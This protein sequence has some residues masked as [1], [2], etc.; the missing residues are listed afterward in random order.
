MPDKKDQGAPGQDMSSIIAQ[1]TALLEHQTNTTPAASFRLELAVPTYEGHTDKKSVAD[2]LQEMQDYRDA[3]AITDDV[4]QRVLPVALTGSAARWRRRQSFQSWTHFEQLLRAEFLPPGYVVRMKDELRARSQAEKE[5]L[6]EYISSFQEL[7]ERADPSAPEMERVTR[8]IRQS[9][10]RFQAYLR[11]RTFS[12]LDD[13]AKAAMLAELTYQ[14]PSP[15]QAS[16]EPSCAWHCSQIASP[17]NMVPPPRAL[18]PFIH[19]TFATQR[20]PPSQAQKI[21]AGAFQ[22]A[23]SAEDEA[24]TRA[25]ARAPRA[26]YSRETTR[27]GG[28]EQ[29]PLTGQRPTAPRR[30]IATCRLRNDLS[31]SSLPLRGVTCN[32]KASCSGLQAPSGGWRFRDYEKQGVLV[33]SPSCGHA[34]EP[35][36]TSAAERGRET[37]PHTRI[38]TGINGSSCTG[39]VSPP[40]IE[41]PGSR[42]NDAAGNWNGG[43]KKKGCLMSA[44]SVASDASQYPKTT[45]GPAKK[46]NI[47]MSIRR[48][49]SLMQGQKLKADG[50]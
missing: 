35:R 9:H 5:S 34:A 38:S 7:Y 46:R 6:Q 3:Q 44:P 43:N 50:A 39:K 1:L 4:L 29:L 23:S 22:S 2:F 33:V 30:L 18:D 28:G 49:Q 40:Q 8:A 13:L 31:G 45:P 27:A 32:I 25:S 15:P 42:T 41:G 19:R 36:T 26:S 16:L 14:P 11:G 47:L 12:S 17:G 48:K 10:P 37:A 20:L 24:T 21:H